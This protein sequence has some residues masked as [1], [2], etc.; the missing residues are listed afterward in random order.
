MVQKTVSIKNRLGL[1]ARA[2]SLFVQVANKFQAEIRVKKFRKPIEVNGKSI[3]GIIMLAAIQ[4]EKIIIK[5]KGR[6]ARLAL[7]ELVELIENK[8]GED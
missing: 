5:A 8:F 7:Q 6:D 4:G 3:M 1:H 2:A